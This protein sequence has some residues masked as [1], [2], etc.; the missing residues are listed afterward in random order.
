[1][2]DKVHTLNQ[3]LDDIQ[4][5]YINTKYFYM[6]E[7]INIKT[8]ERRYISSEEFLFIYNSVLS[9]TKYIIGNTV[10]L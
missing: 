4:F 9:Y 7:V 5:R 6:I 10:K 8:E 2:R 1:M 3:L